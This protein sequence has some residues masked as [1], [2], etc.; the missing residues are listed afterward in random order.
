MDIKI[1]SDTCEELQYSAV[2]PE[3]VKKYLLSGADHISAQGD[4]GS[5]LFQ[6]IHTPA[7]NIWSSS[8]SIKRNASFKSVHEQPALELHF[9]LGNTIN[10]T[11]EGIGNIKVEPKHFNITYMPWLNSET[12]FRQGY[13]ETFDVH[14]TPELLYKASGYYPVVYDFVNRILRQYAAQINCR[15]HFL[16][17]GMYMIIRQLK[18]CPLKPPFA[19]WFFDYKINELMVL[20]LDKLVNE[21]LETPIK[22]KAHDI[23]CLH[24]AK[25]LL[26][27]N[28]DNP[29]S[30]IQLAHKAGIND[31]KLKKG[32]KQLFG[33]SVFSF[34]RNERLQQA[35]VLL[36]ETEMSIQEIA[37]TIGFPHVSSFT[38][39]F[40]QK[41]GYPPSRLRKK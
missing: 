2:I 15:N 32:F 20:V 12:V 4:Y 6:H 10:Y 36:T 28:L 22:L 11:I 9:N 37:Y 13:H 41:F 5:I 26:T 17:P 1:I 19:E 3:P 27:E 29:C 35:I 24:M 33:T 40:T 39:N 14:I 23:E 8:Y 16:T 21:G 7:N 30:L 18:H 34:L 25:K 38:K 31:F